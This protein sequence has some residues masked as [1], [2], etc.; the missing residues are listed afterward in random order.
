M[1]LYNEDKVILSG[2]DLGILRQTAIRCD[3]LSTQ[4]TSVSFCPN[5]RDHLCKF[6]DPQS[7]VSVCVSMLLCWTILA[8]IPQYRL[9]SCLLVLC[10]EMGLSHKVS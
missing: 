7:L 10:F 8:V 6:F 2:G 4:P 1:S 3:D 5:N 9:P